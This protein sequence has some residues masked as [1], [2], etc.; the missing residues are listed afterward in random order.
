VD[1]G[2]TRLVSPSFDLAGEEAVITFDYW[3]F[4]A[5]GTPDVFT[6]EISP[7][8]GGSWLVVE[9]LT[10]GGTGS[11]W[12]TA[13]FVAG[14]WITP[15]GAVRVRF[16]VSDF[17][18]D[19]VTEAAVDEFRVDRVACATCAGDVTGDGLVDV[20]DL[21]VT[22][23]SWGPCDGCSADVDGDGVVG[24]DDLLVLLAGWGRC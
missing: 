5:N 8:D 19:S 14:D 6:A 11:A 24:V 20:N 13:S 2:P 15:T 21:L 10:S 17:P 16:S 7:D 3:M 22:L 4:T 23:T 1:G 12:A 9:S 18:N